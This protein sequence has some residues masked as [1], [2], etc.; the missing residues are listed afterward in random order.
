M[1]EQAYLEA[2]TEIEKE[3]KVIFP[4]IMIAEMAKKRWA[5]E[6]VTSGCAE[7]FQC[8]TERA[9]LRWHYEGCDVF[10][11]EPARIYYC[12][13]IQK[14]LYAESSGLCTADVPKE[15]SE[16]VKEILRSSSD[17]KLDD[18]MCG[19]REIKD[20][21]AFYRTRHYS[22]RYEIVLCFVCSQ[23][24]D[25]QITYSSEHKLTIAELDLC[26]NLQKTGYTEDLLQSLVKERSAFQH[27]KK[28]L[29]KRLIERPTICK[30]DEE[31]IEPSDILPT[32]DN[33][34]Y[35]SWEFGWENQGCV[36]YTAF[37]KTET[38]DPMVICVYDNGELSKIRKTFSQRY[39]RVG[40][41]KPRVKVDSMWNGGGKI[42]YKEW[43][44]D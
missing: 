31:L 34:F 5:W 12:E 1:T 16:R 44:D 40:D 8:S 21:T 10:Y 13:N 26:L 15:Y 20:G 38:D 6:N 36:Y 18:T 32:V 9:N 23:N 3:E 35:W 39:K 42:E 19:K 43:K 22:N 7:H 27:P 17:Y 24:Q 2:I 28:E 37:Y 4:K 25:K 11:I 14:I 30:L 33:A 41:D 29:Y